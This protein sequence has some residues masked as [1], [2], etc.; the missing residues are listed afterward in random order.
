MI[1][2]MDS[3][4]NKLQLLREK[5]AASLPAEL[6]KMNEIWREFNEN[7]SDISNLHTLYVNFHKLAGSGATFGFSALSNIARSLENLIKENVEKET[8]LERAQFAQI[9]TLLESLR[10]A[11]THPERVESVMESNTLSSIDI[12]FQNQHD[13]KDIYLLSSDDAFSSSFAKQVSAYGYEVSIFDSFEKFKTVFQQTTPIVS[14]LDIQFLDDQ[15]SKTKFSEM[16]AA[17]DGNIPV[18][19]L[20]KSGDIQTRLNAVRAGALGFFTLPV[21]I[22]SL[23]DKLDSLVVFRET[24]PYRILII[25]DST[26][27]SSHYALILEQVGMETRVV[28]NPLDILEHLESFNPELILLDLHMPECDGAELANVIRQLESFI[29][30]PIVYL[31][32][33]TD[34]VKQI[35]AMT[36]G[37]DEFLTKPIGPVFLLS[38]VT[39]RVR[40]SRVLRSL[41]VRDSLTG[42]L[43]H[44][45]IKEMLVIEMDRARRRKS[46]MCYVMIDIDNFKTVNNQFGHPVG[47]LVI[48]HLSS[49]LSQ[50]IRKTD[51]IGRYGGEEFAVI[52][53]DADQ[54]EALRIMNEIKE[55][56]ANISHTADGIDFN[57]TLS[58]GIAS[59]P[60]M[61][62]PGS[63]ND[64]ADKALY[65]AKNDGRNR[66]VLFDEL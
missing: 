8:N 53:I 56:F 52:L 33:E 35:D 14:V 60:T 65:K 64:A 16:N 46:S 15:D 59:F 30:V 3:P 5:Y 18:I 36:I 63:I 47:D 58:S 45:R 38:T 9:N 62:D 4:A 49:L 22:N 21:D 44:T 37:G 13:T 2:P 17:Q 39:N 1:K 55:T 32:G 20:S 42:L 27:L 29:T 10:E 57:V 7:L 41:M 51:I 54:T 26:Y 19:I 31:S 34:L 24:E 6:E 25:D 48:K 23:I 66:V 50:R 11:A 40:R 12:N 43:N 61:Q 28:N